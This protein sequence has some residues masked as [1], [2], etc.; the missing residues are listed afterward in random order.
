M[1]LR[2]A[3]ALSEKKLKIGVWWMNSMVQPSFSPSVLVL[4]IYKLSIVMLIVL[5]SIILKAAYLQNLMIHHLFL[6]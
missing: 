1:E 4:T 2:D 5:V 6:F 3:S